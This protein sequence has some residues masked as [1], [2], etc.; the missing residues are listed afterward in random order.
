MQ[1]ALLIYTKPGTVESLSPAERE[2]LSLEYYA[3]RDEPGVLSG[4]ALQPVTAATTVRLADGK[5]LVTD[6]PFADTKEVFGGYYLYEA[7]N[8]DQAAEMAA[9]IPALRLGGTIEIRPL[10]G[11]AS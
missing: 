10:M 11:K 6:G 8:L 9:R 4:A 7:D 3:L 5:P 2:A 1:Y